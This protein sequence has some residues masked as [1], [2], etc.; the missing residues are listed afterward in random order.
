MLIRS[1]FWDAAGTLIELAE[2]VGETYARI[3][4][5]HGV[6]AEPKALEKA[7]RQTWREV[8]PPKHPV[9]QPPRDD[10]RSWWRTLVGRT[11]HSCVTSSLAEAVVD[12]VFVEL[13][14]H[15]AEPSAW[16]LYDEVVPVLESLKDRFDLHILSNFDRRLLSILAGLGIAP[17]FKTVTLSSMV[18][19]SKPDARL[20][21]H[22]LA[23]AETVAE[24]SLHVGDEI[25]ADWLGATAAG[26]YAWR[27][28]RPAA[29]LR[30]LAKNLLVGDYSCL[31][32][33]SNRIYI[34]PP[35]TERG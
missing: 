25:E 29:D 14:D 21:A 15:Y 28:E 33:P 35:K 32:P 17:Y 16:R 2:P 13:Y 31:R 1:V 4:A 26:L 24:E 19:V 5:E 23:G 34:A 27:V 30:Q 3:A 18:G 10:D 9:G 20:F 8:G 11:L 12:R 7:F 22:A 6:Q